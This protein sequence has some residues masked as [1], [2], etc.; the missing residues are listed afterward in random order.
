[1]GFFLFS[2]FCFVASTAFL[3]KIGLLIWTTNNDMTG[4][5]TCC[6]YRGGGALLTLLWCAYSTR[7]LFNRKPY[8]R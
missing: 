2:S 6:G 4:K 5:F 7:L 1:L 3:F 8:L